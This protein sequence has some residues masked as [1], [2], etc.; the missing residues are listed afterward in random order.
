MLHL[1]RFIRHLKSEG[2]EFTLDFPTDCLPMSKGEAAW[3]E[4]AL[5]SIV[6]RQSVVT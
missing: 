5:E 3:P 4:S 6:A 2:A 1:D